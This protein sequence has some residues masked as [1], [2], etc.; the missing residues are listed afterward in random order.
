MSDGPP[1]TLSFFCAA[2]DALVA[3]NGSRL[4][5]EGDEVDEIRKH[6]GHVEALYRALPED[7]GAR[8]PRA[9]DLEDAAKRVAAIRREA[10]D[11][12]LEA[13]P[14]NFWESCE[15]VESALRAAADQTRGEET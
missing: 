15:V 6:L 11:Y 2:L 1:V 7:P 4:L 13:F 5:G 3:T 14:K 10:H 8:N 12:G 9:D